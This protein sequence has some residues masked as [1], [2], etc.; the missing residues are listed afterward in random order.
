MKRRI[1]LDKNVNKDVVLCETTNHKASKCTA[2]VLMADCIPF[3]RVW[4]RVPLFKRESY[5]GA[6]EVCVISINRN[7]YHRARRSIERVDSIYRNRLLL[8]II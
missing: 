4:K 2:D 5:K 1:K 3:T 7:E 6:S 8:N